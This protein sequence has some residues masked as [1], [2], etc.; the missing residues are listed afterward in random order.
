MLACTSPQYAPWP[1]GS[2]MSCITITRGPGLAA[3]CSH[4][5]N[6]LARWPSTG[7]GS[8][9]IIAVTAYPTI[10]GCFGNRQ[11]M[12]DDTK[13]VSRGLTLN[14]SMALAM[15]GDEIFDSSVSTWESSAVMRPPLSVSGAGSDRLLAAL[16]ED[17]PDLL[18][19]ALHLDE[20]GVDGQG[21][22][23]VLRGLGQ[24]VL[25]EIDQ[26][27]ARQR[28]EVRRIAVHDFLAVGQRAIEVA[29]EVVR[30][31]PLVPSLR[32]IGRAR[33][34]VA[35]H[36]DRLRQLARLHEADALGE[37]GVDRRVARAVPDRPQGVVRLAA[38]GGVRIVES[39]DERGGR[40]VVADLAEP[41]DGDPAL[42]D[43]A[44]PETLQQRR[45][46]GGGRGGGGGDEEDGGEC[47][48][49]APPFI[50]RPVP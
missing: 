25:L 11:T 33:D 12:S 23:E 49:G 18:Q 31:R 30:G 22:L 14:V 34:H 44:A 43:G 41:L 39:L 29:H 17:L 4:Q 13:P 46:L 2:S 1:R 16:P 7:W 47:Q 42:L 10:A 35:E 36:R 40:A 8:A 5:A 3:T 38:N 27:E 6:S 28:V 32:E 15:V 20:G 21:L 37:A 48:H 9:R 24:V 45:L 50:S 19:G 26:T